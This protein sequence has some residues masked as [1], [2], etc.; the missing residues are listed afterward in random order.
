MA[1]FTVGGSEEGPQPVFPSLLLI[2]PK[3][4]GNVI[5]VHRLAACFGAPQVWCTGDRVGHDLDRGRNTRIP[6]EERLR[7]FGKVD[8]IWCERAFEILRASDALVV[9]VEIAEGA[10]SLLDF[11]HHAPDQ[12]GRIWTRASHA[13]VTSSSRE[14]S[15]GPNT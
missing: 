9:G 14:A 7:G 1:I 11:E 8:L 6:P 15:S 3:F 13:A 4:S 5:N 12:G 2:N 10:Q